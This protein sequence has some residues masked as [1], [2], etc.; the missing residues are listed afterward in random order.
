[1]NF[2]IIAAIT[3]AIYFVSV[4]LNFL[5]IIAM[6]VIDPP[7]KKD[8]SEMHINADMC[9]AFTLFGPIGTIVITIALIRVIFGFIAKACSGPKGKLTEVYFNFMKGKTK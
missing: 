5:M 3:I 4:V 9:S 6:V 7:N 8:I 1:M 2:A